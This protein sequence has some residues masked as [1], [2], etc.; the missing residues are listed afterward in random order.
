MRAC[1]TV[2]TCSFFP[3]VAF[4]FVFAGAAWD[5]WPG[6]GTI[7][8]RAAALGIFAGLFTTALVKTRLWHDEWARQLRTP[9]RS[10]GDGLRLVKAGPQG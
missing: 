5:F 6:V 10:R 8:Y 1:E 2:L 3:S 7:M 9:S 4:G